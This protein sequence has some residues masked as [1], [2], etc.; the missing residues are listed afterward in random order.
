[1][2]SVPLPSSMHDGAIVDSSSHPRAPDAEDV[3]VPLGPLVVAEKTSA[4]GKPQVQPRA[5]SALGG[6]RL[7]TIP[8]GRQHSGRGLPVRCEE[9]SAQRLE[10]ARCL[11]NEAQNEEGCEKQACKAVVRPATASGC[12]RRRPRSAR[13]CTAPTPLHSFVPAQPQPLGCGPMLQ[14]APA[15]GKLLRFEV[16]SAA[17]RRL[18]VGSTRGEKFLMRQVLRFAEAW[19]EPVPPPRIQDWLSCHKESGQTFDDFKLA[20]E[21]RLG[22]FALDTNRRCIHVLPLSSHNEQE[23]PSEALKTLHGIIT[24]FFMPCRVALLRRA[25]QTSRCDTAV[26]EAAEV[27]QHMSNGLRADSLMTIALT[28]DAVRSHG[29]CT[30]GV[31]GHASRLGVFSLQ[32]AMPQN[33]NEKAEQFDFERAAKLVL[34]EIS[35]MMGLLHCCYYRCLMNGSCTVEELDGTPPYLCAMCLKK[36]H[37]VLGFDPLQRY[38]A[39]S[40]AWY[41][42]RSEATAAWY[43]TRVELV[44]STMRYNQSS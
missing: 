3:P 37:L 15:N 44:L 18:A 19:F 36:L 1:M 12:L 22:S 21:E 24:A 39:L 13:K 33:D 14:G 31:V 10:E 16:P 5:K 4:V 11:Q 27:L 32:C 2:G 20:H 26:V 9:R 34:H 6:R 40:Q 41:N 38:A 7:P 42:A 30:V 29:S 8:C 35:H 23:I 25:P 17:T 28:P 43:A